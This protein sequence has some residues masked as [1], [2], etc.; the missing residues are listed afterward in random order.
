MIGTLDI[1]LTAQ[2]QQLHA[3]FE[4]IESDVHAPLYHERLGNGYRAVLGEGKPGA[5]IMFIGEAPGAREAVFG[6]P[7]IGAAGH[8]LHDLLKMQ[9]IERRQVYLTNLVKDRAPEGRNPTHAEIAHYAQYLE[10][11]IAILQPLLIVPMGKLTMEHILHRFHVP[12]EHARI[13]EMH[14][15][16]LSGTADYGKVKIVPLLHPSAA[17]YD[18]SCLRTLAQD[19]RVVYRVASELW[20]LD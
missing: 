3:L 13:V 15:Q 9:R 1:D 18:S 10:R 11:E 14:G 8:L 4:E 5:R 6:R 16:V 7:F 19:I 2:G 17:L 20:L 12:H